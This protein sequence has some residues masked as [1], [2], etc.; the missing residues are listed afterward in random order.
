MSERDERRQFTDKEREAVF[1]AADGKSEI[2]GAPLPPGW[3][4]DHKQPWSQGGETD[5]AN[6]QATTAQENVAK[7]ASVDVIDRMLTRAWQRE[8][9]EKWREHLIC[10]FLLA[11]LP[12]A[13]KT[14][15]GLAAACQF[16][17]QHPDGRIIIL[18]PNTNVR[19]RW[20][21]LGLVFGLQ[22]MAKEF[23]GHLNDAA[24]HGVVLTYSLAANHRLVMRR[25]C[26]KHPVLVIFDEVHHI[27]DRKSWGAAVREGFELAR[28]RLHLTGTP[29]RS[30][31]DPIPFLTKL[32]D[33]N[34]QMDMS[35]DYPRALREG[36]VRELMFHRYGGSVTLADPDD[37]QEQV[38][39]HTDDELS[40]DEAARRLRALLSSRNYMRSFM[41]EAWGK[42]KA[43]RKAKANAACLVLAMNQ[44]H[45]EWLKGVWREVTGQEPDVVV[46]D[47]E[48][49]TSTVDAFRDNTRPCVVAVRQISEGADISRL[50][51]LVYATNWRTELFF[52]QAVGRVMRYEGTEYDGEAYVYMPVDPELVHHAEV[53]EAFQAQVRAEQ[54][55][56]DGGGGGGGGGG[57]PPRDLLIVDSSNAEFDGLTNRGQHLDQLQSQAVLD[58]ANKY[59]IS[60][61]KA[62]MILRDMQPS[63]SA[64]ADF[65]S[66]VDN[67]VERTRLRKKVTEA[68][69][70]LAN[71][72]G[73][74]WRAVH[75]CWISMTGVP[76]KRMTLA[77]LQQK[78]EWIKRCEHARRLLPLQ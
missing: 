47:D 41:A 8:F 53:I 58:F 36:V 22:L 7:G 78:Y 3:H 25:L 73:I 27:A 40:E 72:L 11:A 26:A 70:S 76:T 14:L 15:A 16:R 64:S 6:A 49:T 18:V 10:D 44:R 33:G 4:A 63:P 28:R 19:D 13:G 24:F 77:Q 9:F 48:K 69:N 42:L 35:Y 23:S 57:G 5:V 62:A 67:E 37:Y 65:A 74:E 68:A 21:K 43:V 60:Q 32:A 39:L 34:Y 29:F 52:R 46:S 54:D 66:A 71:A 30:D 2:S 56:D 20:R 61:A 38:T 51:V 75:E 1:L 31:D 55:D 59:E 17:R 45:A 12:A 50:M